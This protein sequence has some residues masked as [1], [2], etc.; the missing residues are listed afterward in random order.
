MLGCFLQ[1]YFSGSFRTSWPSLGCIAKT[2]RVPATSYCLQASPRITLSPGKPHFHPWHFSQ[3]LS[4]LQFGVS[5]EL[6]ILPA[7]SF[8]GA[9]FS[10]TAHALLFKCLPFLRATCFLLP[11]SIFRCCLLS[12]RWTRNEYE[13]NAQ[14]TASYNPIPKFVPPPLFPSLLPSHHLHNP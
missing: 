13:G 9:S 7:L 8:L 11:S 4:A 6:F 14:N 2:M 1:S 12:S 10:A 5:L 3:W